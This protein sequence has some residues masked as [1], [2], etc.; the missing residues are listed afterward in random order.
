[1]QS[2]NLQ[3][4]AGSLGGAPT[5]VLPSGN[6]N[7]PFSVKGDTFVNIAAALQ[8][9]CDQQ[10]NACANQA[11]GGACFSVSD[12]QAQKGEW[13]WPL[14]ARNLLFLLLTSS[15]N[16]VRPQQAARR[17]NSVFKSHVHSA[18]AKETAQPLRSLY[19]MIWCRLHSEYIS[20]IIIV[21]TRHLVSL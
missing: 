7:R 17:S 21:G 8:R 9:S 11:N 20:C 3:F 1:V 13:F 15:Q 12:C 18:S 2:Q 10:F 5:P 4:F 16:S 6:D 14:S 19:C